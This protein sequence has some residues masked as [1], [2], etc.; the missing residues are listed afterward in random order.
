MYHALYHPATYIICIAIAFWGAVGVL[1]YIATRENK[2]RLRITPWPA[3]A[4]WFM[5]AVLMF[6][7]FWDLSHSFLH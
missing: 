4:S 3:W 6:I 2:Q 1:T 7:M 5:W